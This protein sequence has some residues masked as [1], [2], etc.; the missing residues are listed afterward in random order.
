MKNLILSL[1]NP[2]AMNEKNSLLAG[3]WVKETINSKDINHINNIFLSRSDLKKERIKSCIESDKIY[4]NIL[5]D[6]A[7]E[8][9]KLHSVQLNL[10]AWKIILTPWLKKF[11]DIC[12][13]KDSLI[14]EI[15]AN[16]KIDKIYGIKNE[17]YKTYSDDSYAIHP[18][19]RNI[20]WINIIFYK[21]IIFKKLELKT[22]FYNFNYE[23][24]LTEEYKKNVVY[25]K[26]FLKKII[27]LIFNFFRVFIRKKNALIIGT[28]LPFIYEKLLE[29]SCYQ[30]PQFYETEKINYEK[31]DYNLRSKIKLTNNTKIKNVENFIRKILPEYLPLCFVEN[32]KKIYADCE[33][34]FPKDPKFILS[35][36]NVD[37]DEKFKIFAAKKVNNDVPYYLMQHGNTYFVEDFIQNRHEY[38]TSTK[39]F[40]LGY[41]NNE[42]FKSIG[43]PK[44]L[45]KKISYNVNNGNLNLLAPPMLG[46]FFPYDRN[47]EF[48]RSF[49][50]ISEFK[51]K[52]SNEINPFLKLRLH[53]NF[54]TSR[55]EWFK[56]E[57]LSD[58]KQ[59]QIDNGVLNYKSFLSNSRLNLFFYDSSGLYENLIFNIPSI[60]IWTNDEKFFYNHIND[61]FIED[62]QLLKDA[63]VI[64]GDLNE[65]INHIQSYWHN[66]DSWWLSN[67]TQKNIKEFNKKLNL[68]INF[69]SFL[70]LRKVL[71]QN[72]SK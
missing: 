68:K 56:K 60:G 71:I 2:R 29:L 59:N 35:S 43:N 9:N 18:N 47:Q 24:D 19:S 39:F 13:Q 53:P 26:S 52:I 38:E 25:K 58:Y 28:G 66:I 7:N 40:T 30:F 64:F 42:K 3:E 11:I 17:N 10:K 32:F 20:L 51:K 34:N 8:F 62:Y 65:M 21:L 15:L 72:K 45:G 55:G 23:K 22:D 70:N 67:T 6:L 46:L 50:L 44:L 57:Y 33:K 63:K 48:L 41:D 31:Y 14:D 36:Y 69:S 54:S 12:Y 4:R 5:R 16:Y 27:S 37:F 1:H 49:K 61:S